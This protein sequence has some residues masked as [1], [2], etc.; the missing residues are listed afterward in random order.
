MSL[1]LTLAILLSQHLYGASALG[2]GCGKVHADGYHETN[3]TVPNTDPPRTYT[4]NIPA[5]YSANTPSGLVLSFHG[6]GKNSTT[7]HYLSELGNPVFNPNYISVYPLGLLEYQGKTAWQGSPYAATF[8]AGHDDVDFVRLLL[9]HLRAEYCI[10]DTRIYATGKSEG[11]G[12]ASLLATDVGV[13]NQLAAFAAAS[14]AYWQKSNT[15]VDCSGG[16]ATGRESTPFL[17]FHGSLDKTAPYD[18]K[19]GRRG[20]AGHTEP[21]IPDFLGCWAQKNGCAADDKG[22]SESEYTGAVNHTLWSCNGGPN[23]VQGYWIRGMGHVWLS[24]A[25]NTDDPKVHT[26]LDAMPIMISFFEQHVKG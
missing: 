19:I 9:D 8:R 22:R 15:K 21:A 14:G 18:G 6:R 25:P 16:G 20:A 4:I 23:I 1:F 13:G 3:I 26:V 17:E 5:S 12:F 2:A 10:D 7:Q 24:T 11:G